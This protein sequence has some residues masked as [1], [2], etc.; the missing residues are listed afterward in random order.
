VVVVVMVVM[1]MVAVVGVGA[2]RSQGTLRSLILS[3]LNQANISE[4]RAFI[5]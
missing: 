1:V 4:S 3:L 5:Y 2:D